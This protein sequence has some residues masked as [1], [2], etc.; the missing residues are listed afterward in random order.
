AILLPSEVAVIHCKAHTLGSDDI[1]RGNALADKV[2]KEVAA[3]TLYYEMFPAMLTPPTCPTD[4]LLLQLQAF[5]TQSD[6]DFWIKQGLE[7]DQN[8][9]FSKEGK[10][11]IPEASCFIFISQAH[12]PGHKSIASTIQFLMN[13]FYIR[14]LRQHVQSFV[15][16]CEPCM[17]THP[18]IP[19]KSQH[20]HL[21]PP[22]APFTHLQIDFTHVPKIGKKQQYLLV[23]VDQFSR[24][25]EAFVTSRED[26]RTVV[27]ILATEIIP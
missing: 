10:I 15:K 21:P 24:W 4:S 11:G 27:K 23:I 20:E 7:K 25:P 14:N 17:R 5:A 13:S 2:A 22:A 18:N 3:K 6:F 9:L 26:A 16:L 1:S 19:H 8:D 12:G